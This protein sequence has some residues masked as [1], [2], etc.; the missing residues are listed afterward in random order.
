MFNPNGSMKDSEFYISVANN[1]NANNKIDEQDLFPYEFKYGR[2]AGKIQEYVKVVP[3][4]RD[5]ISYDIL[6]RFQEQIPH[7]YQ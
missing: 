7:V 5:N 2:H 3:F 6:T 4:S 1:D